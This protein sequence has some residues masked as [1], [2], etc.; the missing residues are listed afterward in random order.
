[1]DFILAD[2]SGGSGIWTGAVA[3]VHKSESVFGLEA[4]SKT[5]LEQNNAFIK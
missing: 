3:S 4:E 5:T 1:M 2:R